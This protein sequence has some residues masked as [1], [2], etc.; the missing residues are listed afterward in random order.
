VLAP[1]AVDRLAKPASQPTARSVLAKLLAKRGTR[2]LSRGS[3]DNLWGDARPAK[4]ATP[5]PQGA[6]CQV[7]PYAAAQ[8]SSQ[9]SEGTERTRIKEKYPTAALATIDLSANDWNAIE[10]GSGELVAYVRPRDLD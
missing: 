7:P 5:A 6:T 9:A 4:Q 2:I 10:R 8:A 3:E 1:S